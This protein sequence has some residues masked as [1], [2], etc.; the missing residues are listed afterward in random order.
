MSSN[1]TPDI[2]IDFENL[3]IKKDGGSTRIV[4]PRLSKQEEEIINPIIPPTSGIRIELLEEKDGRYWCAA[5]RYCLFLRIFKAIST[6]LKEQLGRS[7]RILI[8]SDERP[9]ADKLLKHSIRV[10]SFD[11]HEIITQSHDG[12]TTT[13]LDE[14]KHSGLSTPYT[15]ACIA[16]YDDLDAVICITASHNSRVWNGIKFYYKRPIPIAGDLMTEISS[17]ATS[18]T[19]IEL[20]EPSSIS[21]TSRNCEAR[22]NEYVKEIIHNVIPV[23]G[24]KGYRV[25]LWPYMGDA[26]GIHD[27][28][29]FYG[30]DVRKIEKPMEPPDPTVNLRKDEIVDHLKEC[31]AE[32]A[33]LLDADR[34]RIVFI[35]KTGEIF[36]QLNPNELYTAMHNIL[37]KEFH[38]K[39]INVRTVPSD[40][41]CDDQAILTIETGVGYK[42]LGIVQYVSSGLDVDASQFQ[43]ALV[44]GKTGKMRIKLDEKRKFNEFFSAT[45][46]EAGEGNEES[47]IM[48]L[49]EESGGHTINIVKPVFS[50]GSIQSLKSILPIIGDKFPAPAIIILCELIARGYN[51][52]DFIDQEISGT[53]VKIPANDKQKKHIMDELKKLVE[54]EIEI[55]STRYRVHEYSDNAG[56]LDII[57]LTHG[58]TSAFVRPSG[59]GNSVRVYM[60]GNKD[61]N[62]QGIENIASYVKNLKN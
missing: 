39:I 53:R 50:E 33:V 13:S 24:L 51:L 12:H 1:E 40:P 6:T 21:V 17:I 55:N 56:E 25:V 54:T 14:V 48:A 31:Q 15:S 41:R 19:E 43:E 59:T 44:Y 10:F 23:D 29:E 8:T 3:T 30:V 16:I 38:K 60:F 4:L 9:T 34:D 58:G 11:G 2:S 32:V 62:D 28:L 26:R 47:L 42:H 49:W 5:G 22:V 35:V 52:L 57:G 45:I 36:V 7:A 18:L 27:I 37:I 61:T 20:A 46:T